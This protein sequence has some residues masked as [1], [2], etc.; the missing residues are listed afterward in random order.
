MEGIIRSHVSAFLDNHNLISL[1]Q[2]GFVKGRSTT[3][4]LIQFME[5]ISK[6]VEAGHQ[7]DV[8]YMDF[9]KAFDTVPHNRLLLKTES[10][11][12]KGAIS[13]WI[14]AF[15]TGRT[16]VVV[17][18]GH[19]SSPTRASS[20]VPQGS[21]LG[22]LLFVIYINDLPACAS[23]AMLLYADD[24]KI[25]RPIK[26]E[27]DQ[28]TL[29]DDLNSLGTWSDAWELKFHP[30]K[31][32]LL[33]IGRQPADARRYTLTTDGV[34]TDLTRVTAETDLGVT[35]KQDLSF[36]E[37]AA[38]RAKKG[39]SIMGIIR[40]S[41]SNLTPSNFSL[42][43]KALV[44][45]HLE[46]AAPVWSPHLK[47]DC[48][49]LED[50]QRRATRQVP[51]LKGLTY[52]ERLERLKLP[53]LAYRRLRGDM[54]EVYKIT[55]GLYKVDQEALLPKR[56]HPSNRGHN[57]QLEKR[58]VTSSTRLHSFAHRTITPWNS[59]P[60]AVV[61]APSL[62]SFKSRLDKHWKNLMYDPENAPPQ[63]RLLYQ[64]EN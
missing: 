58:R 15:L 57:L 64:P 24:T 3:L 2:Y 55:H 28:P 8:C 9:R 14:K 45:P 59:L 35:W 47:K 31:C 52:Q 27:E 60:A 62:N 11:G 54:I 13:N 49:A 41:Y 33:T 1:K 36:S 43:F 30:Q 37:E 23:S 6:E 21:I 51:Q 44:R 7:V 26:T 4:Q 18:N 29:Q 10:L 12:I 48:K 19:P 16:Q 40:R 20:G 63:S 38:K 50:V 56:T 39:N 5:E 17:V 61:D 22:P 42:L 46:Y 34:T 25:Y 32:N 53:T